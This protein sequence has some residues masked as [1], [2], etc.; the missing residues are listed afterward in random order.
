MCIK[1]FT[2]GKSRFPVLSVG[3]VLQVTQIL[4]HIKSITQGKSHTPVLMREMFFQR[5]PAFVIIRDCT[6]GRIHILVLSVGNVFWYK[7][8]NFSHIRGVT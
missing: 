6:R 5:S 3:N 7:N 2:Q 1:E 4:S 8:Q